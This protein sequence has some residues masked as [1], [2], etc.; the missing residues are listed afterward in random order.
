M[1]KSIFFVVD[2]C[3]ITLLPLSPIQVY[4]EQ[5]HIKNECDQKAKKRVEKAKKRDEQSNFKS[6]KPEGKSKP[7]AEDKFEKKSKGKAGEIDKEI[8]KIVR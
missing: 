2:G 1:N 5:F 8:E 7:K 4:H 6:V 3:K